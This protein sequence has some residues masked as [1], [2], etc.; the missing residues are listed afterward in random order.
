[1]IMEWRVVTNVSNYSAVNLG[2]INTPALVGLPVSGT[3]GHY[4]KAC[5]AY[6][7]LSLI[8]VIPYVEL[9]IL[10]N[11]VTVVDVIMYNT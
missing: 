3:A 4:F 7:S 1:M 6:P 2:R 5:P 10:I 11:R 9:I 8:F